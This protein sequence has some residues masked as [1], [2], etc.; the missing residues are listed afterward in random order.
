[1]CLVLGG[2]VPATARAFTAN[3]LRPEVK[4]ES[5]ALGVDRPLEE[6]VVGAI[7]Y[8]LGFLGLLAAIMIILA[9][10]RWIVSGGNEEKLEAAKKTLSSA[11]IGLIIVIIAWSIVTFVGG[12]ILDGGQGGLP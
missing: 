8:L 3:D 2:V 4:G 10:F 7:N 5:I 11:V 9:G 1:M 12:A 6:I